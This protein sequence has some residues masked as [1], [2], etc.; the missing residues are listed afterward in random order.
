MSQKKRAND[1]Q[2]EM[3]RRGFLGAVTGAV[4]LGAATSAGLLHSKE[5]GARTTTRSFSFPGLIPNVAEFIGEFPDYTGEW[6]ALPARPFGGFDFVMGYMAEGVQGMDPEAPNF[7]HGPYSN[8]SGLFEQHTLHEDGPLLPFAV[9]TGQRLNPIYSGVGDNEFAA[10]SAEFWSRDILGQSNAAIRDDIW[11][12]I[13]YLR[14]FTG[15]DFDDP[16][17]DGFDGFGVSYQ[18]PGSPSVGNEASLFSP[19]YAGVFDSSGNV[20]GWA[21]MAPTLLAPDTGYTVQ[22]RSGKLHPAYRGGIIVNGQPTRTTAASPEWPGK[23]R[24]GG[25]WGGVPET[26][27]CLADIQAVRRGERYFST[28][29]YPYPPLSGTTPPHPKKR[30][31]FGGGVLTNPQ[32]TGPYW[33]QWW[34][35]VAHIVGLDVDDPALLALEPRIDAVLDVRSAA[36][37]GGGYRPAARPGWPLGMWPRGTDFFWGNYNLKFGQDEEPVT[38]H[39]QSEVP[40]SFRPADGVPELF[41]CD[42]CPNPGSAEINSRAD[43]D[44]G[45]GIGLH[46]STGE[47][48]G[49]PDPS[50]PELDGQMQFGAPNFYG[51]VHGVSYPRAKRADGIV[52]Y[53]FRN[54]LLWP[55]RLNCTVIGDPTQENFS[56]INWTI[57]TQG[58]FAAA[59]PHPIGIFN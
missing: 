27:D 10:R 12:A 18:Y 55:P 32:G 14:R 7:R 57:P 3:S 9:D 41:A 19:R 58:D 56:N 8:T 4:G 36:N 20:A 13:N 49:F 52:T 34:R 35:R 47:V 39:Y 33:G 53:H 24:D 21:R 42:L 46:D 25:F 48:S 29:D 31:R 17:M 23:V 40:T 26:I 30:G 54:Y 37:P 2:L 43:M 6:T 15:L 5:V 51:R 1:D 44:Q 28:P 45:T 22:F 11:A 38:L 16:A 59:N 50:N